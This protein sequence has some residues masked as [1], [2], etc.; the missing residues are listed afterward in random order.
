MSPNQPRHSRGVFDS[1]KVERS[2]TSQTIRS[3]EFILDRLG[4]EHAGEQQKVIQAHDEAIGILQQHHVVALTGLRD[5]L[6]SATTDRTSLDSERNV[7]EGSIADLERKHAEAIASLQR[8]NELISKISKEFEMGL[9]SNEEQR[10]QLKIKADQALFEQSRTCDEHFVRRNSDHRQIAELGKANA[11]F[12]RVKEELETANI[13]MMER[14]AELEHRIS[15]TTSALPP[16]GPP[17]D[18]PL[19]PLPSSILGVSPKT[20]EQ[21]HTMSMSSS[22]SVTRCLRLGIP[23]PDISD[24]ISPLPEPD[25]QMIQHVSAE[26][27][28]T[29]MEKASVKQ[30]SSYGVNRET[31]EAVSV[32]SFSRV[33]LTKLRIKLREERVRSEGLTKEVYDARKTSEFC[34]ARGEGIAD[35]IRLEAACSSRRRAARS[36][37]SSRGM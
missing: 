17:P 8:D 13:K 23:K 2:L 24:P 1:E 12:E 5:A 6:A 10:R 25:P 27:D 36:T 14:I 7:F 18:T 29:V 30:K 20:S 31:E 11:A 26:V 21:S 16:E 3:T 19:P 22:R 32:S 4:S 15:R 33:K 37:P 35:D 34:H 9:M 28:I